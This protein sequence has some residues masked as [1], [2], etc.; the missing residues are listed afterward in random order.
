MFKMFTCKYENCDK[1]FKTTV[2]RDKHL[3]KCEKRTDS[4]HDQHTYA[5]A[6]RYNMQMQREP[7]RSKASDDYKTHMESHLKLIT[8]N[9]A[10]PIIS[11]DPFEKQMVIWNGWEIL[12]EDTEQNCLIVKVPFDKP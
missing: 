8:E 7:K 2:W 11:T 10:K 4:P 1:K 12:A 5:Y 3:L 9:L 6:Y